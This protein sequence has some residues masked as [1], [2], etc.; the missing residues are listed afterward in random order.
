VRPYYQSELAFSS[1]S[2]RKTGSAC[3]GSGQ[4]HEIIF[5]RASL[6]GFSFNKS[7]LIP[8]KFSRSIRYKTQGH[9]K[10]TTPHIALNAG[11][12]ILYPDLRTATSPSGRI[13]VVKEGTGGGSVY[14]LQL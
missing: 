6:R 11:A 8:I 9:E 13:L 10:I 7:L 2:H 4:P 1:Q 5:P 14:R 3:R 12:W